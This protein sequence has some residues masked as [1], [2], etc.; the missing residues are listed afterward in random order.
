MATISSH[1]AKAALWAA[2]QQG[3]DPQAIL[4]ASGINPQLVNI[5]F[6]RVNEKQMT[7][8]VQH[9][10]RLLRDEFMGFTRTPCKPDSF[11]C[12]LE[13][14]HRCDNLREALELGLRFYNLL[15]SDIDTRLV[16][17]SEQAR[18]EIQ[19]RH[20]ELDPQHFYLEFWMVIWHRLSSWIT[21]TRIPLLHTDFAHRRPSHAEELHFMFPGEHRFDSPIN[22]LV[23]DR[24]HL[25]APLVRS[26]QEVRHFLDS[27]PLILLTI[28]GIDKSLKGDIRQ[29][30]FEHMP[31]TMHFPDI[32]QLAAAMALS[33]ATLNRRLKKEGTSYQTIKDEIRRDTAL[34]KLVKDRLPV[35]QV[36][37]LVGFSEARSFTRAFKH[38]TGLSPRE[39]CRY[40]DAPTPQ[41]APYAR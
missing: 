5:P 7:R 12:M 34:T 21:A 26:P 40:L 4:M 37:E 16:E 27:S 17:G 3:H 30:L 31:E 1:H 22:A 11:A 14:I 29:H 25:N 8:L 33:P 38:W 13:S 23:F 35:Y 6:S 15:T 2:T 39:Y 20:P 18:I 36:A 10:W 32:D 41:E 19:F 28:P 9:I 24:T